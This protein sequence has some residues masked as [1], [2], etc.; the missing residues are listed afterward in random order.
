MSSKRRKVFVSGCF[1]MLHSGHVT[2]LKEASQ[3]GEIYLGLDSDKT[4]KELKGRDP[5]NSEEERLY[6]LNALPCVHCVKVNMD[7]GQG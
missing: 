3:F 6:M 7:L 5:V 4:L 1:D 2:F